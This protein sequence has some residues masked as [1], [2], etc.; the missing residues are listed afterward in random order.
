MT[1]DQALD[2]GDAMTE[3]FVHGF[4]NGKKFER[5]RIIKQLEE[6]IGKCEEFIEQGTDLCT[7]EIVAFIKGQSE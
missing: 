4:R 3:S 5:E 1:E 7:C 6:R 2:F